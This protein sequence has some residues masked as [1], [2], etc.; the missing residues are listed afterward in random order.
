MQMGHRLTSTVH[1]PKAFLNY[2]IRSSSAL[3]RSCGNIYFGSCQ[4]TLGE[5]AILHGLAYFYLR[6]LE[7]E[8][9]PL[10]DHKT[11]CVHLKTCESVFDE[12]LE[13]HLIL[14]QPSPDNILAL[15]LGVL[16]AHATA[17]EA[18]CEMLVGVAARHCVSIP[19]CERFKDIRSGLSK[20]YS[21]LSLSS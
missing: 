3:T 19:F 18:L 2:A 16:K 12:C 5:I 4:A 9:H 11:Y 15:V 8:K 17:Q 7:D 20:T 21:C 10:F 13:S 6:E 1:R 14:L